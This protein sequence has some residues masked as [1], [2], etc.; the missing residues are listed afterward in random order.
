[1]DCIAGELKVEV[2]KGKPHRRYPKQVLVL[3][4]NLP[5]FLAVL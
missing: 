1:V 3:E 4:E 2:K 5:T